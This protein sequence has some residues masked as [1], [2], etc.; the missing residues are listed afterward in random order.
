[1][2]SKTTAF[3]RRVFLIA[4][5]LYSIIYLVSCLT[6]YI[7]PLVLWPLTFL[8]LGFPFLLVGMILLLLTSLVANRKYSLLLLLIIALGFKNIST[9]FAFNSPHKFQQKK[10]AGSIRVL[11]WNV[12]NFIN[13]KKS[14]DTPGNPCSKILNFIKHSDADILCLQDFSNFNGPDYR[15]TF[16]YIKDSLGYK[17]SYF[18][19]NYSYN[20][21][22]SQEQYGTPVFSRFPISDSGRLTFAEISYNESLVY[23]TIHINGDSIRIFN[24][25]FLSMDIHTNMPVPNGRN[26][27]K[28]DTA[29]MFHSNTFRKLKRFDK[30]HI[31]QAQQVKEFMNKSK[32]PFIFCADLNSVPTT[33]AYHQLNNGL[34]D[35]FLSTG[36]GLGRTYDSIS[37]TLRI[38]VVLM[39]KVLKPVQHYTAHIHV[40]DHFPNIADF[41][42]K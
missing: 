10:T 41:R 36:F 30:I 1:M 25:H 11:S 22:L 31:Q 2:A 13:C 12:N 20:P 32:L 34:K 17:Y 38:D 8:S 3:F 19:D 39:S 9:V 27:L 6:P 7:S 5:I 33:Y 18:P 16:N 4:G 14:N 37:S 40:S 23:V 15:S 42:I 26:F 24:T 21:K 29:L 28:S 35:A